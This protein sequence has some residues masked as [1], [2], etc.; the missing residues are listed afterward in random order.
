MLLSISYCLLRRIDVNTKRLLRDCIVRILAVVV[1]SVVKDI[2]RDNDVEEKTVL[3]S[4]GI[5]QDILEQLLRRDASGLGLIQKSPLG[6][7]LRALEAHGTIVDRM[8]LGH[9]LDRGA[10]ATLIDR[11]LSIADVVE[12]IVVTG[13]L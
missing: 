4:G 11:R 13:L 3:A 7:S 8:G 10:E 5:R 6:V 1:A 9:D 12:R 2:A